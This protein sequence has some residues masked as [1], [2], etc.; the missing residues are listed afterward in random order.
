MKV[1]ANELDISLNNFFYYF[2]TYSRSIRTVCTDTACTG[3]IG[4]SLGSG[5]YILK[6]LVLVFRLLLQNLLGL[7]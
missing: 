6:A 5:I 3:G 4:R 2:F 1:Q 7:C